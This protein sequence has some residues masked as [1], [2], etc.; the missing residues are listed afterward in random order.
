[1][2][3]FAAIIF[4]VMTAVF[5]IA[6]LGCDP[7]GDLTE[8][9]TLRLYDEFDELIQSGEIWEYNADP[10]LSSG[11]SS[12]AEK[13]TSLM[14][15]KAAVERAFRSETEKEIYGTWFS[16][17]SYCKTVHIEMD[18]PIR[19]GDD[20][21]GIR[22]LVSATKYKNGRLLIAVQD[23]EPDS[24]TWDPIITVEFNAN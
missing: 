18:G 4:A 2:R 9:E 6:L 20:R 19:Q 10:W 1:M 11:W 17:K 24:D 7:R 15:I 21:E 16:S 12:E 13:Q 5:S 23:I 22:T 3:R 8:K 14:F